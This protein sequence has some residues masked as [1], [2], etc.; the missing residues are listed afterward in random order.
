[1]AS[2]SPKAIGKVKIKDN[3]ETTGAVR[4]VQEWRLG[5]RGSASVRGYRQLARRRREK[6]HSTSLRRGYVELGVRGGARWTGVRV[7]RL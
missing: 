4:G 6:E 3:R 5:G 2:S 7:A 1:M